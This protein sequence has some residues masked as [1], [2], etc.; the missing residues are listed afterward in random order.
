MTETLILGAGISGLSAAWALKKAGIPARILE[1]EP[2]PGGKISTLERHG[3]R[4]ELGPNAVQGAPELEELVEAAGLKNEVVAASE[5]LKKRFLVHKG[6]LVALPTGPGDAL[7]S[8]FLPK[9]ILWRLLTEPFRGRGPGPHES[10][11][12]FVQRRLGPDVARLVEPLTLGIFAGDPDE[13]AIGYAFP[14]IYRL[15][16]EH[17][18]LLKGALALRKAKRSAAAAGGGEPKKGGMPKLY[19]FP[20]GLQG[21]ADGLA[22]SLDVAY[23]HRVDDVRPRDRGGFTLRGAGPEGEFKLAADRL[24]C[25][26]PVEVTA[27]LLESLG[28]TEALNKLTYAPVAVIS[29]GFRTDQI[30]HPLD[31]FGFLAPHGED[32]MLLG[33]IFASTLFE[34]RA[35]KD[36]AALT[37]MAGGRRRP[38]EVDL[39]DEELLDRVLYDLG[40]LLGI[41]S[42]PVFVDIRRWQPGIAQASARVGGVKEAIEAIERAHPGLSVLGDWLHGVGVPACVRAGW[43]IT[44]RLDPTKRLASDPSP[45]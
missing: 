4:F 41:D 26:L 10:V 29:L 28:S 34:G 2:T 12:R 9:R 23:G 13:L 37:V 22:A 31:G 8:P 25:A 20:R 42:E 30:R 45:G 3:F 32:R 6:E 7:R 11:T 27:R 39:N 16:A 35:P 43:G 14:R 21:L 19:S 40:L 24:I 1:A 18:G 36:H 5:K 17:G 44:P 15:E 38:E 33:C